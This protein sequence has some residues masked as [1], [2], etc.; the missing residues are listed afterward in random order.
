MLYGRGD[1]P[2][3][4][5][6]ISA[7]G[8]ADEVQATEIVSPGRKKD[9]DGSSFKC[10]RGFWPGGHDQQS[11]RIGTLLQIRFNESTHVNTNKDNEQN[12]TKD[13]NVI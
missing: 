8:P 13:V 5:H 12:H 10:G 7:W 2:T 9:R 4:S 6:I 11:I 3:P 1:P